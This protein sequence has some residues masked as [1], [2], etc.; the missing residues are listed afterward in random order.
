MM[1]YIAIAIICLIY[2]WAIRRR[3]LIASYMKSRVPIANM[4]APEFLKGFSAAGFQNEGNTPDSMWKYYL[5]VA[6][7]N[8]QYPNQ[9][10][11]SILEKDILIMKS[12]NANSYRFSVEFAR[13]MPSRDS[14]DMSYY[15]GV[16]ELLK[17][18][19]LRPVITMFHFVLPSW[20]LSVWERGNDHFV[21]F[22][23]RIV[24]ELDAYDPVW[25]TLNEPYLYALHGYMLGV[26]PPFKRNTALC[27]QVLSNMLN[28]HVK[29][30]RH[31]KSIRKTSLVGIAKNLMPI[32]ARMFLSPV[33]Q[34]LRTQFNSW[35][36][37]S[38]FHF[39]NTGRIDLMLLATRRKLNTFQWPVVDFFGVNH[40]TEMS[41]GLQLSLSSPVAVDLRPPYIGDCSAFTKAGWYASPGSWQKTLDLITSNCSLPIIVTE[42]GISD[43]DKSRSDVSRAVAMAYILHAI[44]CEPRVKGVLVWTFVDNVEWEQE[45]NFGVVDNKRRKTEIYDT[46]ADFFGLCAV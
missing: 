18:H 10:D 29:I 43:I 32:T 5:K 13:V 7:P 26:R 38:F 17:K 19:G 44:S 22:A 25:I 27:L 45:V 21:R 33:D 9:F 14:W 35:F 37:D 39:V 16:C 4:S 31:C 40:Y 11:L 8:A 15:V 46:V 24:N 3:L 41:L 30:Y 6:Q 1:R 2:V 23:K 12:M 20:A 34:I 42:C 36:N 28:D